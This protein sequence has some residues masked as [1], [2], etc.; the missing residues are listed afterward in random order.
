MDVI[1]LES[2]SDSDIQVPSDDTQLTSMKEEP[3]DTS[4]SE[5]SD[6]DFKKE[7]QVSHRLLD[8]TT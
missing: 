6:S 3:P 7:L 5:M 2:D 8:I 1:D 4:S